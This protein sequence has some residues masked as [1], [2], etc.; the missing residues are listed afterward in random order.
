MLVAV[1][2]E[3]KLCLSMPSRREGGGSGLL[4]PLVLTLRADGNGE[5]HAPA[6]LPQERKPQ[7]ALRRKLRGPQN[8]SGGFGELRMK[9]EDGSSKSHCAVRRSRRLVKCRDAGWYLDKTVCIFVS[10]WVSNSV[11]GGMY[12][13]NVAFM[14]KY[15]ICRWGISFVFSSVRQKSVSCAHRLFCQGTLWSVICRCAFGWLL[16]LRYSTLH[17]QHAIHSNQYAFQDTMYITRIKTATY[18]Y[19]YM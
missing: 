3:V 6:A 5:F 7:Y 13:Y 9:A 19:I 4:A 11:T 1:R 12:C 8:Q 14:G 15:I 2:G 17:R 16:A 18:I 10:T